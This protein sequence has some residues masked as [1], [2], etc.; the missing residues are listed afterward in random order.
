MTGKAVPSNGIVGGKLLKSNPSTNSL[1]GLDIVS[2]EHK[3]LVEVISK[4]IIYGITIIMLLF[5]YFNYFFQ[6]VPK[7]LLL[8][9]LMP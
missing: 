4:H 8:C 7:Q 5:V 2:E 3:Q 6:I 1:Y 9:P